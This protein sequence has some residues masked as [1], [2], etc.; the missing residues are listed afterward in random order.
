MRLVQSLHN[1]RNPGKIGFRKINRIFSPASSTNLETFARHQPLQFFIHAAAG[2]ERSQQP[3]PV[4]IALELT[5]W[6]VTRRSQI[7]SLHLEPTLEKSF[8]RVNRKEE[9]R[10]AEADPVRKRLG[11]SV[12]SRQISNP[13]PVNTAPPTFRH[14]RLLVA[15][16][17]PQL[18][19]AGDPVLVFQVAN[20]DPA[21]EIQELR[22]K[23]DSR[24]WHGIPGRCKVA[25]LSHG[26]ARAHSTANDDAVGYLA[27]PGKRLTEIAWQR[28]R[29]GPSK[30]AG[31]SRTA[32]FSR[33]RSGDAR[34]TL[35]QGQGVRPGADVHTDNQNPKCRCPSAMS[36][37]LQS[38]GEVVD[39]VRARAHHNKETGVA[40]KGARHGVRLGTSAA[41]LLKHMVGGGG[42]EIRSK[43]EYRKKTLLKSSQM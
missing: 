40:S 25:C 7:T 18:Q 26:K 2:A 37:I 31:R 1:A 8:I 27:R 19:D 28:F 20:V 42:V 6:K 24:C 38:A 30:R 12:G 16:F 36:P 22:T 32:E 5:G 21:P 34:L 4:P 43:V 3:V 13:L 41:A 33:A 39:R 35:F 9:L 10:T 23:T 15:R 29:S 17:N 11:F 14:K